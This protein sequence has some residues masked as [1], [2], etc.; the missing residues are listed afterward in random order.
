MLYL[1]ACFKSE[2]NSLEAAVPLAASL[3]DIMRRFKN[4]G[5]PI[6]EFPRYVSWNPAWNIVTEAFFLTNHTSCPPGSARDLACTLDATSLAQNFLVKENFLLLF[7]QC[8]KDRLISLLNGS[9]Q[10]TG[11]SLHECINGRYCDAAT[12]GPPLTNFQSV[13][14]FL[15]PTLNALAVTIKYPSSLHSKLVQTT[16]L[17]DFV[18]F[19]GVSKFIS[20]QNYWMPS[21]VSAEGLEMSPMAILSR[22]FCFSS[23]CQVTP[24]RRLDQCNPGLSKLIIKTLDV[25][26][27]AWPK[28]STKPEGRLEYVS[29]EDFRKDW[30]AVKLTRRGL[31]ITCR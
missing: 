4:I 8:K 26:N 2:R 30:T 14:T 21:M 23:S 10:K 9:S 25:E 16:I 22:H 11:S 19:Y 27:S 17:K 3:A 24:P 1:E 20:Q 31:L 18:D 13:S 15:W 29:D 7:L 5:R 28:N 6:T 12:K